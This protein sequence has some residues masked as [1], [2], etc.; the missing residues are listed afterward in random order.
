MG[1]MNLGR[2]QSFAR[3]AQRLGT[4]GLSTMFGALL[5]MP[6]PWQEG[7]HRLYDQP[8]TFWMFLEQTLCE[9]KSCTQAVAKNAARRV[10]SG[11]D[12]P[13]PDTGAYC[14]ARKKLPIEDLAAMNTALVDQKLRPIENA[15]LWKGRRVLVVDGST[16]SMPDTPENQA[17]YPQPH[18]QAPGCGFPVMRLL[19]IFSLCTG[20]MA[21]FA[22][23]SLARSE[24]ALFREAWDLLETLDVILA[25]RGFCGYAEGW[26]L[27]QRGVDWVM[28]NHQRRSVGVS[29]VRRIAK[30]DRIV[31]WHKTKAR[32]QW[33][34][35]GQ[36][37]S[38]PDTMTV[39]EITAHVDTPG[40]RTRI[41]LIVTSLLDP[42]KFTAADLPGFTACAGCVNCSCATSRPRSAWISC[43]AKHRKWSTGNC[44]CTSSPTTSCAP[45]WQTPPLA[46]RNAFC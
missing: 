40:F 32:P 45:S 3:K 41:I 24:R 46:A 2:T 14:K 17:A 1:M 39:R 9:D 13:S 10:L 18:G 30:N 42:R 5:P 44:S 37:S 11:A 25:D 36:W 27:A 35:P 23:S 4:Q 26:L 12:A 19:A 15:R 8:R 29:L 21:H 22:Q 34:E 43:A 28:R 16:A 20:A 33:M 6:Q 38:M 31:L 7:R